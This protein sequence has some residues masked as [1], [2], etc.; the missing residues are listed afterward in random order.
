MVTEGDRLRGTGKR[1]W[2]ALRSLETRGE[3]AG[4][5]S[6]DLE[7]RAEKGME[8]RMGRE[9]VPSQ[10]RVKAGGGEGGE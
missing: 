10:V 3:E 2:G 6:S 1:A 4:K 5:T 9:L 7:C 8:N